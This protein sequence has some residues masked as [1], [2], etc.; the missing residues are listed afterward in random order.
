MIKNTN[1]SFFFLGLATVLSGNQTVVYCTPRRQ[2][3]LFLSYTSQY[4]QTNVYMIVWFPAIQADI[5]FLVIYAKA[6]TACQCGDTDM[7]E[8]TV[9]PLK[10]SC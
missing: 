4:V 8:L 6:K 7:T 9:N 3:E 5:K 10:I 1:S 2:G